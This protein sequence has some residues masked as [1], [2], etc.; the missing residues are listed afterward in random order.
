MGNSS[1]FSVTISRKVKKDIKILSLFT[2]VYCHDHHLNKEKVPLSE[3]GLSSRHVYCEECRQ[4]LKYAIDRRL[5]CPLPEKPSCKHCH[6]H[7][8]RSGHREQVKEIMRYSG[9][10]L[11]R[12]GRI[13]L[14]LHYLF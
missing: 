3:S 14:L 8:Y 12:R 9:K 4:F 5:N 6:I 2:S 11:V 7:C 1:Y 10:K 13:D